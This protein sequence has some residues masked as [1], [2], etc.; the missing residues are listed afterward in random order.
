MLQLCQ[1]HDD[2]ERK[3][4][5]A[6][7]TPLPPALPQPAGAVLI[8]PFVDASNVQENMADFSQYDWIVSQSVLEL[9]DDGLKSKMVDDISKVDQAAALMHNMTGICPIM[10]STSE[11]ECLIAENTKLVDKLVGD[12]VDV[13]FSTRPYL[14]HIYQLLAH[15]LPEAASE[16]QK[17]CNWI[18]AH[19]GVWAQPLGTVPCNPPLATESASE[20][21]DCSTGPNSGASSESS[22]NADE[23]SQ[24]NKPQTLTCNDSSHVAVQG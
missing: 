13:T 22:S 16:K 7:R 4:M 20:N 2:T 17:I 19:C 21:M 5:F 9:V 23:I 15:Y 12:G 6:D 14:C 3:E 11:H 24:S 10:V 1:K 18:R 8:G